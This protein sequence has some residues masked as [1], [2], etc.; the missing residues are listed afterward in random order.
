MLKLMSWSASDGL[1]ALPYS[2][3]SFCAGVPVNPDKR[4]RRIP[5]ATTKRRARTGGRS[6]A[7]RRS[8]TARVPARSA[9]RASV[10]SS[11]ATHT[12]TSSVINS[13]DLNDFYLCISAG[14]CQPRHARREI[15]AL[16]AGGSGIH[17][18]SSREV[19]HQRP[20]CVTV[21]HHIGIVAV[22]QSLRR[23]TPAFVP[24]AYVNADVVE[25][26]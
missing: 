6:S 2:N 20:V 26:H 5:R 21:N 19:S 12:C 17:E 11:G 18:Q 16:G 1:P 25:V 15:E 4:S 10:T 22:R 7:R 9:Y 14:Y 23:W 13:S 3:L 8:S 24:M